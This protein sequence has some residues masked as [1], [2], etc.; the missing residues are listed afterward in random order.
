MCQ[1]SRY[2]P[3][4]YILAWRVPREGHDW[5]LRTCLP[6]NLVI[7]Y[8]P[9]EYQYAFAPGIDTKTVHAHW[10][11]HGGRAPESLGAWMVQTGH[12]GILVRNCAGAWR[13][14]APEV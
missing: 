12:T 2:Y 5:H 6:F 9:R 10:W 8:N 11:W 4:H 3:S 13:P 7:T 1:I 14:S